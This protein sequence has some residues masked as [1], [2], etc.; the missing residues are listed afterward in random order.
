MLWAG[1]GWSLFPPSGSPSQGRVMPCGCLSQPK[2]VWE[3]LLPFGPRMLWL[4]VARGQ[5]TLAEQRT[6]GCHSC[7]EGLPAFRWQTQLCCFKN[8]QK[9]GFECLWGWEAPPISKSHAF[10]VHFSSVKQYC[11]KK[12]S[13]WR[14]LWLVSFFSFFPS[15]LTTWFQPELC[16]CLFPTC[17]CVL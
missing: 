5:G 11:Y 8:K 6:K 13:S 10:E 14:W 3:V 9:L 17:F 1:R 15:P 2:E 4:H 7:R 16:A 12:H